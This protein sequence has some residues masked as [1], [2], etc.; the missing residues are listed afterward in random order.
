MANN[1]VAVDLDWLALYLS[2]MVRG[3]MRK[4]GHWAFSKYTK[5]EVMRGKSQL[6][7]YLGN[8][9][10]QEL[11]ALTEER[12]NAGSVRDN[13]EMA[14]VHSFRYWGAEVTYNRNR[15]PDLL[16]EFPECRFYV[17]CKRPE[18]FPTQSQRRRFRELSLPV[19]VMHS[20]FDVHRLMTALAEVTE[21]SFPDYS[22]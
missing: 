21:V 12:I 2:T 10:H 20:H 4:L 9:S 17:E 11:L 15:L 22:V 18:T 1:C 6:M 13:N 16:I 14:I 8:I 3:A 5:G 7:E 19:Y